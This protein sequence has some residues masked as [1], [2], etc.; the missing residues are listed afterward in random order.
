MARPYFISLCFGVFAAFLMG[1]NSVFVRY[2]TADMH[3]LQIAV[4]RLWIACGVIYCLLKLAG[5]K[6]S[7]FPYNRYHC[8]AVA[9][10][11]LNYITFHIGLESTGATN[12][13]VLENTA[14]FFVLLMLVVARLEKVRWSDGVATFL[15]LTGVYL[16]VR[17]DFEIGTSGQIGDLWEL[18]AGLSWAMFTIGSAASVKQT[19]STM[20]RMAVLLKILLPCGLVLTPSLA[21]YPLSVDV[22][23][24]SVLLTLGVFSTALGYFLWYEAMTGVSSI[25][26]S[27]L[28]VLS[29]VFTFVVAFFA[30]DEQITRDML[31]GASLIILGV[32]LPG[33]VQGQS[34]KTAADETG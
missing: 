21:L 10:F 12:A 4:F 34:Q 33:L 16:T 19:R 2:L 22:T 29:V 27:L 17:H 7:I 20:D 13:M 23:D 5:H 6:F 32:I 9:G 1:L 24:V 11:T 31:I 30:L 3:G 26:A 18:G 14:P 8:L 25:T 15:A 28:V